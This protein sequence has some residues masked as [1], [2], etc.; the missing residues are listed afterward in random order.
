V[1]AEPFTLKSGLKSHL[2]A[3]HRSL[4]CDPDKL[5]LLGNVLAAAAVN[6]YGRNIVLCAV[7]SSTSPYLVAAASLESRIPLVNYRPINR[8]KGLSDVVFARPDTPDG[9]MSRPSV[10]FIDDVVTTSATLDSAAMDLEFS[11]WTVAGAVCLLDRRLTN[12][13]GEYGALAIHSIAKLDEAARFGLAR[14][15]VGDDLR[16]HIEHELAD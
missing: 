2:Y 10:V 12:D 11:G 3:N 1:R 8:E 13:T 7:E 5:A 6:A 14:G 4:V 16:R 15:L 9:A